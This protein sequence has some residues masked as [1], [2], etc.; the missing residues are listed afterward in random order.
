MAAIRAMEQAEK[1]KKPSI[2]EM[3]TDVY[4]DKPLHLLEQEEELKAHMSR[5]P[6]YYKFNE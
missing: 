4:A 3:F 1:K 6:E 5:H 2:E